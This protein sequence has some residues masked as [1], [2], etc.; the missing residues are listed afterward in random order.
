MSAWSRPKGSKSRFATEAEIENDAVQSGRRIQINNAKLRSPI[1]PNGVIP[2]TGSRQSPESHSYI[3]KARGY[4]ASLPFPTKIF[5]HLM[6]CTTDIV[7]FTGH[8]GT[9]VHALRVI[10][11]AHQGIIPSI[12]RRLNHAERSAIKSGTVFIFIVDESG[13]N[14]WTGMSFILAPAPSLINFAFH[15]PQM[16]CSGLLPKLWATSS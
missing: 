12:T 2:T 9:T 7:A 1:W 10:Y 8:I 3:Y 5:H 11:A 13:I 16:A 15:L 6:S 4:S 14:R